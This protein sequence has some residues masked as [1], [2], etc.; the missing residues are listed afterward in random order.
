MMIFSS[1]PGGSASQSV[2]MAGNLVIG[3]MISLSLQALGQFS[4]IRC[5]SQFPLPANRG[6]EQLFP[7]TRTSR[8]GLKLFF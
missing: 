8:G 6:V 1:G 4:S 3:V 2:V 5:C 7:P